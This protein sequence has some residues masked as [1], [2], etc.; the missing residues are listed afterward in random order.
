MHLFLSF[1]Y[2]SKLV[3]LH[4]KSAGERLSGTFFQSSRH[5][6]GIYAIK[7]RD[8]D[9]GHHMY[10]QGEK[11]LTSVFP[12]LGEPR[13]VPNVVICAIRTY[14]SNQK[15]KC[16]TNIGVPQKTSRYVFSANHQEQR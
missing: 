4:M 15:A 6:P 2:S 14:Q 13:E 8:L 1:P 5:A 16:Y 3:H 11:G 10:E 9:R 7:T 12:A